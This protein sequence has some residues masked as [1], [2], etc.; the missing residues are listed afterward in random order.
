[1]EVPWC[2]VIFQGINSTKSLAHV[3]GT[4]FMHIKICIAS[5]DQAYLSI[6]KDLQLMKAAK[7]GIL[8]DYLHNMISSISRLQDKSSEVVESNIQRNSRGM[9][10]SNLTATYDTSSFS[11]SCSTSPYNNKIPPQKGLGI[12]TSQHPTHTRHQCDR[13]ETKTH[14]R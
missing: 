1:M 13:G 12:H 11:T 3:I 5:T 4:K 7:K 14:H 10:S 2:N 6:Y 9:S 8:N